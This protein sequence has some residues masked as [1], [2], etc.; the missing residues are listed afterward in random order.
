MLLAE[1][2]NVELM[3]L[4]IRSFYNPDYNLRHLLISFDV[5]QGEINYCKKFSIL[6][7][8]QDIVNT[9]SITQQFVPKR[10]L[11]STKKVVVKEEEE[12]DDE[13]DI[14]KIKGTSSIKIL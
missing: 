14:E 3:L 5:Y 7:F 2:K 1:T 10:Q 4:S 13:A 11:L 8:N 12:T 9:V 6:R